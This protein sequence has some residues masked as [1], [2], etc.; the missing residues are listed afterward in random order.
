[1]AKALSIK[2]SA[3]ASAHRLKTLWTPSELHFH[4]PADYSS[5]RRRMGQSP[6]LLIRHANS[7]A[8]GVA[9]T[10]LQEAKAAPGGRS[11]LPLERWLEAYGREDLIDS[12]LDD[13][14][15]EQCLRAGS[16]MNQIDFRV[17]VISP[18]RRTMETCYYMFNQ[19]PNWKEMKF[20]LHPLL[21][22]KIGISGDVP[23]PNDRLKYELEHMY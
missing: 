9:N 5:L 6:A 21:R 17:M 10:V 1:M 20:V 4:R 23:L 7:Y 12:R 3:A 2:R 16:Y 11:L 15:I 22:E 19:H 14:G 8:N 13:K 18:M